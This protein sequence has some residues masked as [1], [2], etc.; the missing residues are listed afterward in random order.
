MFDK[1]SY[2]T[3]LNFLEEYG[4]NL[5]KSDFDFFPILGPLIAFMC[6]RIKFS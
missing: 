5:S 2:W 1:N 3:M 4:Q 6:E